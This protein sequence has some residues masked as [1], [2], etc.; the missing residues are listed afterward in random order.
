MSKH[1]QKQKTKQNKATKQARV[2]PQPIKLMI[3]RRFTVAFFQI[4]T[5]GLI[6]LLPQIGAGWQR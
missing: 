6:K 3:L 4:F 2:Y 1:K 5:K